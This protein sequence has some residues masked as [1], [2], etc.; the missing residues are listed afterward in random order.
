MNEIGN[1]KVISVLISTDPNS[2]ASVCQS[3]VQV[4]FEGFVGDKHSGMTKRSDSRTK[5]YPRGT[6]IRN[7]RQ[8]SII[9]QEELVEIAAKLNIE[10][11][12]PEWFG[13]NLL[14]SGIS[15]LSNLNLNTRRVFSRG[16]SLLVTAKNLPCKLLTD[17][18]CKHL[19]DRPDIRDNLIN[20]SM[21]KRGV[22]AVVELPGEIQVGDEVKVFL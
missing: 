7:N 8:V 16:V 22:V 9:S 10:S 19:I 5:I 14:L 17:E 3:S 11:L 18:V 1:G 12:L 15:N 21:D 13:A 6:E 4:T 2:I 20:V